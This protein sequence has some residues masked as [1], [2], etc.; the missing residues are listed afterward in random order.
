M[1][2][3]EYITKHLFRAWSL[4][5]TRNFKMWADLMTNNYERYAL[6]DGDDPYLEC[7]E[8][9]WESINTDNT[10]SKEFI[11]YLYQK[12]SEVKWANESFV[13]VMED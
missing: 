10:V 8:W 3:F 4:S 13:D 7:Y 11:E 6:I 2:Y 5:W 1:T 12:M 9:F